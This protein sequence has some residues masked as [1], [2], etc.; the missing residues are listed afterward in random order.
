LSRVDASSAGGGRSHNGN[1][2]ILF[3]GQ[4]LALSSPQ[5]AWGLH[6]EYLGRT[7]NDDIGFI[8]STL[9]S[10]SGDTL[11]LLGVVKYTLTRR[12]AARP[13]F[14][15]GAGA[16]YTTTLIDARPLSGFVWSDTGTDEARRLVDDD[17]WGF[18]STARLGID[19]NM[20]EPSVLGLEIGWTG[21]YNS[22]APAT[23]AG[24]DLGLESVTGQM[25]ALT[26]AMRWGWRF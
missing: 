26:V 17:R 4:Y 21:V 10:I 22:R 2:G 5:T 24:R 25:D 16:D 15:L 18:A 11:L 23:P 9:S 8:P 19:F 7:S 20:M 13:Y 1:S 6:A 14:L 12:G 3:G